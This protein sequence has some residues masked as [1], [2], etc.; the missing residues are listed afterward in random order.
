MKV[1][2][3]SKCNSFEELMK[4]I[5]PDGNSLSVD[6]L[7]IYP[8]CEHYTETQALEIIQ[9][10][11]KLSA[12]CYSIVNAEKI[13]TTDNQQVVYLNGQTKNLAA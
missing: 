1:I 9:T 7:K 10:L 12:I 4:T 6:I 11:E 3:K 5:N 8:G 2:P 13:H